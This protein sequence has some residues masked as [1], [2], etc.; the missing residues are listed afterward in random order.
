MRIKELS[1]L[2]LVT[3]SLLQIA[4]RIATLPPNGQSLV[5]GGSEA[6]LYTLY[7]LGL[8]EAAVTLL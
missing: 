3:A 1:S 6:G 7:T 4:R 2:E 8:P 5:W